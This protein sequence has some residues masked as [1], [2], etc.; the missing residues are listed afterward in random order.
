MDAEYAATTTLDTKIEEI[1]VFTS[2]FGDSGSVVLVEAGGGPGDVEG[3]EGVDS[4]RGDG[5]T[6]DWKQCFWNLLFHQRSIKA[7]LKSLDWTW[8]TWN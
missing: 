1:L 2:L 6:M 5:E 7:R 3:S 8:R 4:V